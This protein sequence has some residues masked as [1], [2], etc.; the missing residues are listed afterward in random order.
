M[1]LSKETPVA[2]TNETTH[3]GRELGEVLDEAVRTGAVPGAAAALVTP[4]GTIH[5]AFAGLHS[6][7]GDTPVSANTMFRYASMTKVLTTV[8]ALQ[9]IERGQLGFDQE[10]ASILPDFGH[11]QVLEGFDGDRPLLRPPARQATVRELLN[12]TSGL[13]YFFYHPGLRRYYEVTGLPLGVGAANSPASLTAPLTADPGTV[14]EYGFNTDYLGLVIE[15]ISGLRLDAYLRANVF[16]PLGMK[17]T[18]LRPSP[19]QRARLM[20]IHRRDAATGRLHTRDDILAADSGLDSGGAGGYGTL[21]DYARFACA[22]L[23]GG[24]LDGAAVLKPETVERMFTDGLGDVPFPTT[25]TSLDHS[26]VV[27][28]ELPPDEY[29][30][31]LGLMVANHDTP[32]MRRAG[33]GGWDGIFNTQFWA[34]RATGLAVVLMT[35]MLPSGDEGVVGMQ[36]EFERRVYEIAASAP[37]MTGTDSRPL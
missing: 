4:D 6:V 23:R 22:L 25:W 12:H 16:E 33:S 11:L 31:T 20:D 35:Q 15:K 17:D 34:D 30:F 26:L 8:G 21:S 18:T 37:A 13:G 19:E 27:D 7:D 24:E 2:A 28:M 29:D 1:A 10:V 5:T 9:L 36:M 32:G 3:I 14:W